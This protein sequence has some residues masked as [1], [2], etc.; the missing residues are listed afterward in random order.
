MQV[1]FVLLFSLLCGISWVLGWEVS[2]G[3]G[4][5]LWAIKKCRLSTGRSGGAFQIEVRAHNQR[6]SLEGKAGSGVLVTMMSMHIDT[7]IHVYKCIYTVLEDLM[8]RNTIIKIPLSLYPVL[9]CSSYKL[10]NTPLLYECTH[11]CIHTNTHRHQLHHLP[12]PCT[13]TSAASTTITITSMSPLKKKQKKNSGLK[14]FGM[15]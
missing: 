13:H 4:E 10:L 3:A 9:Q 14:A 15:I 12:H 1:G 5:W 2:L 6:R 8:R 7:R 11:T